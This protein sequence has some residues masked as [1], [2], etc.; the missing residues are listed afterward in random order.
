[1]PVNTVSFGSGQAPQSDPATL[2]AIQQQQQL[3]NALQ[4]QSMQPLQGNGGRISP[5]QGFAQML[6]S[7]NAGQA[8]TKAQA[9]A[10]AMQQRQK[11][12]IN[13]T[14]ENTGAQQNQTQIEGLDG[15]APT[16]LS[17]AQN[18]G[19]LTSIRTGSQRR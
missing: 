10:D 1:M 9:L 7:Y 2:L 11:N 14:L 18:P 13:D 19:G 3:A 4:A 6:Q 15:E 8:R 17:V 12:Y 5:F 16:P